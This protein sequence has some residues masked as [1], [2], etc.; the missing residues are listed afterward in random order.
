MTS[1]IFYV[2]SWEI[3]GAFLLD[4]LIGDPAFIPHPVVAIGKFIEKTEKFLRKIRFFSERIQGICLFFVTVSF[5]FLVALLVVYGIKKFQKESPFPLKFFL[6]G[7]FIFFISQFL[8]LRG[9]VST[10]RNVEAL[11]KE[12][13]IEKARKELKALVGRDT[14]KLNSKKIR[15]AVVESLSENLNDAVIAPLFYLAL[16]GFPML[17][18]YKTVNTLDSMVGYRN[19]KYLYFGWFSAKMDDI[20]NYIPARLTGFLIGLATLFL[21]GKKSAF[22]AFK[23]MIKDGR[24]HLSPNSGISEAAMAGALGVKLGGP[25]TYEGRLVEKPYIGEDLNPDFSKLIENASSIVIL[26]SFLFLVLIY[27]AKTLL[28]SKF[29]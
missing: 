21:K 29:L 14:E 23:I 13:K 1:E 4:F 8:A 5:W 3:I 18:F 25:A 15:T 11:L 27:L 16:G 9:L 10:G 22:N 24:K 20:F 19:E 6:E 12:G 28:M 17:V 7:L 26:S 2:K